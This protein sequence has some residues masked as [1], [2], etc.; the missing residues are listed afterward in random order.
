MG[1]KYMHLE[2]LLVGEGCSEFS[3][4]APIDQDKFIETVDNCLSYRADTRTNEGTNKLAN[5]TDHITSLGGGYNCDSTAIRP[6]FDSHSTAIRP[7]YD[8]STLR[9]TYYGLVSV[10]A[11]SGLRHC[12]LNDL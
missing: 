4:F 5:A 11:A 2:A 8:N 9:R 12:D 6:P 10:T 7:H 3:P 1:Y